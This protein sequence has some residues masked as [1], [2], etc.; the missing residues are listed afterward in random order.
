MVTAHFRFY[1]EL[2]DFLPPAR[3]QQEFACVCAR[4]ATAKHMIEALG[5]PHTE[6][7]LILVNGVS[8]G[9]EHILQEGD[10][11]VVYPVFETLDV[12]P[13]LQVRER[14]LRKTAFIADAHLGGLARL[15]RMAGFDTLYDNAYQDSEIAAI[16]VQQR[17]IVLTRDR[18]LL[19]HKIITHG[20]YLHALKPQQQFLE[21]LDRLD[22]RRSLRPFSLCVEC[23]APLR[24]ADK[25]Q[26]LERL[27]PSVRLHYDVF[28]TCDVCGRVY[29]QGSHWARIS[30][31]MKMHGR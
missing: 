31:M 23:N 21:L 28:T 3:R 15:L 29:W 19:K 27:P 25:A 20:C 5:V 6:V 7:E 4:A 12:T 1:A 8:A 14:P 24:P 16:G 13:L 11:V 18:D 9:F 17:R 10:R 22:L 30:A 26:V 2:N